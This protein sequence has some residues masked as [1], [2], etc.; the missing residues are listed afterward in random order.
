MSGLKAYKVHDGYEGYGTVIF[1]MNSATARREGANELGIEWGEVESCRRA[2]EFDQYAPGPVHPLTL[3]KHG[4]WIE[5]Q[6]CLRKVSIDMADELE[7]DGL[8]PD[9]FIPRPAPRGGVFCSEGCECS[10]HMEK[11]GLEEAADAL[12]EVFEANFP[13]AEIQHL[14]VGGGPKL[15]KADGSMGRCF[16]VTFR[17]PGGQYGASWDFGSDTC[18][19]SK[20]DEE[21]F[22]AWRGIP[23]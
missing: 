20:E 22:R 4:W 1:A 16:V 19:V 13:G 9:D 2:P 15:E 21:V 3:I 17:F 8:N 12:R 14:H 10:S 6:H 5:C 18:H 7:I 23:A 11:V